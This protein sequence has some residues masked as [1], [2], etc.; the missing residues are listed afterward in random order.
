MKFRYVLLTFFVLCGVFSAQAQSLVIYDA[1]DLFPKDAWSP[2][3][4]SV[5]TEEYY[6]NQAL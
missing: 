1:R 2:A 4:K 5:F 3:C 6:Y